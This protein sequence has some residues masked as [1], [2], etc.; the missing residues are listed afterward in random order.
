MQVGEHITSQIS[1]V[2]DEIV[3]AANYKACQNND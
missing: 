2:K 1:K 3:Y